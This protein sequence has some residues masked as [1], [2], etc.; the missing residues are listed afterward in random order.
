M[1]ETRRSRLWQGEECEPSWAMGCDDEVMRFLPAIIRLESDA[2]EDRMA[3][4]EAEHGHCFWA[5][6]RKVERDLIGLCRILPPS[7]LIF[8]HAIGWG[9][10]R[11]V[12][13]QGYARE[14]ALSWVWANL[15]KAP[16]AL[17]IP[18]TANARSWGQMRR[19]GIPR[20]LYKDFNY[21]NQPEDD[22]L[23]PHIFYRAYRPA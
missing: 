2:A 13:D 17:A 7:A 3:A 1:I 18:I 8:E 5:L 23:R 11:K 22:R 10:A 19:L 20:Q 4:M 6:E 14:A 15:L 16:A 12:G 21:P 9:L